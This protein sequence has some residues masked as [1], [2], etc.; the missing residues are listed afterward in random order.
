MITLKMHNTRGGAGLPDGN[1]GPNSKE[2]PSCPGGPGGPGGPGLSQQSAAAQEVLAATE[3]L[4][5]H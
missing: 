2:A 1:G 3:A 4:T 5:F